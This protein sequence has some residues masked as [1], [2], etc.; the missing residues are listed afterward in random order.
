[1][2]F[3]VLFTMVFL[4]TGP[5]DGMEQ[6]VP[7]QMYLFDKWSSGNLFYSTDFWIRWRFLYRS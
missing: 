2:S 6:M 3:I 7:I 1:M 5:N 4:F